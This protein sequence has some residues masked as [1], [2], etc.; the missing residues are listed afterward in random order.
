MAS[1]NDF[2]LVLVVVVIDVVIVVV[3]VIST[4]AECIVVN[5]NAA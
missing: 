1:T 5:H 2:R 3:V 4:P